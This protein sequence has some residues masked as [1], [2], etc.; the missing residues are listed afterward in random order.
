MGGGCAFPFANSTYSDTDFHF[1]RAVSFP[2]SAAGTGNVFD[3]GY[4]GGTF[5]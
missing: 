1:P 5:D 4:A 2:A 3:H